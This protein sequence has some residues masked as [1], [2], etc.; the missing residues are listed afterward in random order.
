MLRNDAAQCLFR[1]RPFIRRQAQLPHSHNRPD[2]PDHLTVT[3]ILISPT[4]PTIQTNL[5]IPTILKVLA[6]P[7][8]RT[9]QLCSMHSHTLDLQK[10]KLHRKASFMATHRLNNT[11]QQRGK[12]ARH[13]FHC[14]GG[15]KAS[16]AALAT[17]IQW[18]MASGPSPRQ[19]LVPESAIICS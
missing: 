18:Q 12:E 15:G 17:C 2:H 16:R 14:W 10:K 3:I 8:I 7:T 13:L 6:Y 4:I 11:P 1:Q 5:T 9:T 19:D